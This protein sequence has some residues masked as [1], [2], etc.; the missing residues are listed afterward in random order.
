MFLAVGHIGSPGFLP[1]ALATFQGA[2]VRL[3][4]CMNA[5][6]AAAIP[7][8]TSNMQTLNPNPS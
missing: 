8:Q 6:W 1:A 3:V 5:F 4:K 7:T 2:E